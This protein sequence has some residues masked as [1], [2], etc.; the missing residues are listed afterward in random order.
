MQPLIAPLLGL[1]LASG[2]AGA[3][4]DDA[5]M[6]SRI[7]EERGAAASRLER[8]QAECLQR[9]ALNLCLDEARARHRQVDAGLQAQLRRL[10]ERRRLERAT[11]RQA[12]VARK[13]QRVEPRSAREPAQQPIPTALAEADPSA[14]AATLPTSRKS[15]S[16]KA[17]T[18]AAAASE[19]AVAA[20]RLQADIKADQRR[21]DAR[22]ARREAQGKK[23]APLPS[24][25]GASAS[26]R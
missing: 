17:S 5:P 9:F 13:Q 12:S 8:E 10:D 14:E 22:L 19:R 7:A 24:A 3:Q 4:V 2:L 21:I 25:P 16:K 18:A 26:P 11:Q 1:I 15:R 23:N 20:R 6:R